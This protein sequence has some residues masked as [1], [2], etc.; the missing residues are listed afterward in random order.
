[1]P[2]FAMLKRLS[3]ETLTRPDS[4]RNLNREVRE[5]IEGE[6]PQ[7]KWIAQYGLLGD[8][9]PKFLCSGRDSEEEICVYDYLEIFEAPDRATASKVVSAVLSF[10]HTSV[11]LWGDATRSRP[12]ELVGGTAGY[13]KP[14]AEFELEQ[15]NSKQELPLSL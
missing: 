10:G 5:Y 12:P 15:S 4:I 13:L 14:Q 7:V 2:K 3:T 1:M 6:Y 11:E 9:R 8:L